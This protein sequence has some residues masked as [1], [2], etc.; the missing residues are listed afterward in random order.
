MLKNIF[1]LTA[2]IFSYFT[3]AQIVLKP[4]K[5]LTTEN[6]LSQAINY[7]ILKDSK[8]FV[9]IT[10]SDGIN[11]YD[12]RK[13][14]Q[15]TDI[16]GDSTSFKGT[17]AIGL[18]EDDKTNIWS[19]SNNALNVYDR[20][21]NIF[22]H[23][24]IDNNYGNIYIPLFNF[25]KKIY[26]KTGNKIYTCNTSTYKVEQI[27]VEPTTD[28][29]KFLPKVF[30]TKT[31][32]IIFLLSKPLLSSSQFKYGM[33]IFE[34]QKSNPTSIKMIWSI[35][36][37]NKYYD[38]V[39]TN[40]ED[41]YFFGSSI[42]LK[43]IN[44]KTKNITSYCPSLNNKQIVAMANNEDK[45]LLSIQN[46]SIWAL[47]KK[48][49]VANPCS[50]YNQSDAE[51]LK[52]NDV[53]VLYTDEN[54]YLWISLWGRGIG[55]CSLADK[56]FK[57]FF[58][59]AHTK[60]NKIKDKYIVS[61]KSDIANNAWVTTRTDGAYKINKN[62]NILNRIP[63][64]K[65]F[66]QTR[67]YDTYLFKSIDDKILIGCQNGIYTINENKNTIDKINLLVNNSVLTGI[68]DILI[69]N[70]NTYLLSTQ[71]GIYKTNKDFS[72]IYI[73]SQ[74]SKNEVYIR[75]LLIQKKW[76]FTCQPLQGCLIY[77][78][79][80]EEYKLT[81]SIRINASIKH[82]SKIDDN[83]IWLASTIGLIKYNIKNKKFE[84]F[85]QPNQLTST[86]TYAVLPDAENNFWVSHNKGLSKFN[87]V[88]KTSKHFTISDG[89]QG[90]E[91]N[92]SA[93]DK[94]PDGTMFFGG[95]NGLNIFEP[96]KLNNLKN[97]FSLQ[98]SDFKVNDKKVDNK[99][100]LNDADTLNLAYK[101]NSFSIVP[102][103]IDYNNVETDAECLYKILGIDANWIEGKSNSLIR[104]SNIPAGNYTLIIKSK[105]E[106]LQ[107]QVYIFVSNPFWAT[108]WFVLIAFGI[109]LLIIWLISRAYYKQQLRSQKIE[110]E[111]NAAVQAER[112]R[113]A[114][115][116]HDDLGSGL[117]KITYLSQMAMQNTTQADELNK[118]NKTSAA[119]V[120]N[121]SEIIW[122]MKE[123]NNS[124]EDL[125]LHI[126]NYTVEYCESNNLKFEIKIPEEYNN[127]S[128]S[129]EKRR[130]I[131]LV[132]KEILHNIV[133]HAN[134]KLVSLSIT[135]NNTDLLIHVKDDGIGFANNKM[136]KIS[137]N[138]LSNIQKRIKQVNGFVKFENNNG[139]SINLQ[140][141]V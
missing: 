45:I 117:T 85:N 126:K 19:G 102:I 78:L 110:I 138:G 127:I 63:F 107:K 118:I 119:L 44:V 77:T 10:S 79:N 50:I 86:Y 133:K 74:L 46:E 96:G 9:W 70:N 125:I 53:Q 69:L 71:S 141:P 18:V 11:R 103:I 137:G 75:T 16:Y 106:D 105:N 116:M 97:Y 68:N 28:F 40:N 134:A 64:P 92:T 120:E 123:E 34:M 91:Y 111:K 89:L 47:D 100:W 5:Y 22:N 20:N 83:F 30:E 124:I 140:I 1:T 4:L 31:S 135:Y 109:G 131:Y 55:Y 121:M 33:K 128:I 43:K 7:S 72:K 98:L 67:F 104:Y 29:L 51:A 35:D 81:D 58:D 62:G 60:Q 84:V 76:L 49:L 39:N 42:G 25:N 57:L 56:N 113:I 2:L 15:Y 101:N 26:F 90:N 27:N 132:I 52:K 130:H 38:V 17:F 6:G 82:I 114:A 14:T 41:E 24:A 13:I 87:P 93:F 108:A 59:D 129:G 73:D 3:Q 65:D 136:G 94:S 115:D 23:I 12:S 37:Q 66:D 99:F 21:K 32:F 8:D 54:N 61:I 122:A 112:N 95:T 48:T 36:D 139:T 88:N 80:N